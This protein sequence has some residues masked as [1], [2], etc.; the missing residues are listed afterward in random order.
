MLTEPMVRATTE[1]AELWTKTPAR[2]PMCHRWAPIL[3]GSGSDRLAPSIG[4][5]GEASGRKNGG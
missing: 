5:A 2:E 3:A 1:I 4:P